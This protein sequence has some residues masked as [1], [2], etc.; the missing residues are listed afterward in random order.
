MSEYA[1]THQQMSEA[2]KAGRLGDGSEMKEAGKKRARDKNAPRSGQNKEVKK[3]N[4]MTYDG[5][6]IMQKAVDS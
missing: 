6:F 3:K 1:I 2:K 5:G 4:D